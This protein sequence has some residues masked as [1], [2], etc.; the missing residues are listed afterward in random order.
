MIENQEVNDVAV[1]RREETLVTQHPGY[2]ATEQIV[3][4]VAAERRMELF[5]LNRVM[6]SIL[7]FLEILLA[8]RF[9]L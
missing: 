2:V 3:Q 1:D 5:Q 6:W 4:D 8:C 7:V 9:L